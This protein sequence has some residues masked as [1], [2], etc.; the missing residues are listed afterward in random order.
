M[1]YPE[2]CLEGLRK[3]TKP[4][5]RIASVLAEIRSETLSKTSLERHHTPWKE[6]EDG[7]WFIY[8]LC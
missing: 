7:I 6:I 1:H 4:L 8:D 3:A 2:I 5:V